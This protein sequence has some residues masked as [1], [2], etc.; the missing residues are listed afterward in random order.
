MK[1]TLLI[2]MVLASVAM[3]GDAKMKALLVGTWTDN[4][5]GK[6]F[7]FQP[8]RKWLMGI[9]DTDPFKWDIKGGKLIEI[10]PDP[11]SAIDFTI[12]F[13]TK[14]ELLARENSHGQ[15]YFFFRR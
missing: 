11:E 6:T 13:L 8:D 5:T 4:C 14:H 3:A 2:L 1:T 9:D 15:G 7:V 10:R 12:L